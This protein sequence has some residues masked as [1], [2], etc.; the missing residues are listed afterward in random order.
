MK[1]EQLKP[2]LEAVLMVSDQPLNLDQL[3]ELFDD[4]ERPS[5]ALLRDALQQLMADYKDR[6]IELVEVASG[7]RVQARK[8]HAKRIARLWVER[9]QK[10]SRALLETLA[11]I[12]YRQPVTRGDIE[13]IR[14]VG[15]SSSIMK[16]LIE[17]EWVR[18][19]G[20]RDVPGRPAMYATTRN[21]LD[22]FN[23][24]T[25][26]ELPTLNELRELG[27]QMQAEQQQAIAD[28]EARLLAA[29]EEKRRQMMDDAKA[30]MIAAGLSVSDEGEG[31]GDHHEGFDL[32]SLPEVL[33]FS[34]L[35]QRLDERLA[36][37]QIVTEHGAEREYDQTNESEVRR[38]AEIRNEQDDG[39]EIEKDIEIEE[40]TK[41]EESGEQGCK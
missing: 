17:R 22:Y 29:Q 35:T 16:T 23:L 2:V 20:Y 41:I 39:L 13:E 30:E 36:K 1:L 14:G 9:P 19:V 24:K 27:D 38:E 3:G 10:Y 33:S 34:D 37:K 11:L 18:V 25:L 31:E 40:N 4:Y 8:E 26:S 6:G 28:D 7:W 12:A 32:G 15:V 21:F 5:K